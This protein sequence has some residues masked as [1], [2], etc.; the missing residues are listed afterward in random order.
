MIYFI[1]IECFENTY[2][3]WK[4]KNLPK[5]FFFEYNLAR[6]VPQASRYYHINKADSKVVFIKKKDIVFI[7]GTDKSVQF[8]L[9][10][11]I[12]DYISDK[13]IE[14]YGES[15]LNS[16]DAIYDDFFKG[17]NSVVEKAIKI[18]PSKNGKFIDAFCKYCKKTLKIYVKNSLIENSTKKLVPLVFNH[19]DHALLLYI[20][21]NFIVRS[22]EIISISG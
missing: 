19:Q 7:I 13:F 2:F 12:L 15:F 1:N 6:D 21:T 4:Q 10:E 3:S 17:F 9:I 14:I 22:A 5:A 20:D 8:Q 11:A 18:V 16:Y